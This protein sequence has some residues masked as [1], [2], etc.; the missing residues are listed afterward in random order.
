MLLARFESLNTFKVEGLWNAKVRD[1]TLHALPTC[2]FFV[3]VTGI[4]RVLQTF[5]KCS[6]VESQVALKE[7]M[8]LEAAMFAWALAGL[9][10]WISFY[11][12]SKW[13]RASLF[14]LYEPNE[15]KTKKHDFFMASYWQATAF[16]N[17]MI[18]LGVSI[19]AS[20]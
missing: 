19:Y 2:S 5:N 3:Y 8:K 4:Y 13:A 20:N 11:K 6:I 10:A 14:E 1:Q 17:T 9:V 12:I 16:I 18:N 7:W 15:P